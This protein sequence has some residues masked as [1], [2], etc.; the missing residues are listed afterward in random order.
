VL[1]VLL[2][3]VLLLEMVVDLVVIKVELVQEVAAVLEAM[4]A[5]AEMAVVVLVLMVLLAAAVVAV[6]VEKDT[7]PLGLVL[8]V[9]LVAVLVFLDK[10]V[11]DQV[12]DQVV[13]AEFQDQEM[14]DPAVLT[15]FA[16][17]HLLLFLP[18]EAMVADLEYKRRHL[19]GVISVQV[20]VEQSVLSGPAQPVLSHQQIQVICKLFNTEA[21]YG[22]IIS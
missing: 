15:V 4:L 9:K 18:L 11:V 14:A 8:W 13:L 7:L 5:T 16:L 19:E 3:V 17:L 1:A 22:S 21:I 12:E 6:A 2:L 20:V 10:V